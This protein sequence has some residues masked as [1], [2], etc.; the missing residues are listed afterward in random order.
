M[1]LSETVLVIMALL[2]TGIVAAGLFR[3]LPV[4]YTVI[5]VVIGMA[6]AVTHGFFG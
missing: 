2:A 6:L 3:S 4:P 5:L 1:P